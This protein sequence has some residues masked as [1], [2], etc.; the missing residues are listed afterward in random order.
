MKKFIRAAV[1]VTHV[2]MAKRMTQFRS[3]RK[4][5]YAKSQGDLTLGGFL[6]VKDDEDL[7]MMTMSRRRYP[8]RKGDRKVTLRVT[9]CC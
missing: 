6:L 5:E 4:S 9:R 3:F 1:V 7:P 8:C 2:T